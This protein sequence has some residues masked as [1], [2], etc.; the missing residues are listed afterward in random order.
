MTIPNLIQNNYERKTISQ[1]RETQSILS[2]AMRMAEEEYGDVEG[3]DLEPYSTEESILKVADKLRYF[4]KIAIDCGTYDPENK[5]LPTNDYH[6]RSGDPTNGNHSTTRYI[7]KF[8]LLNGSLIEVRTGGENKRVLTFW[9]DTNGKKLPNQYGTDYFVFAYSENSLRP[10]GAPDSDAP[11][12]QQCKNKISSGVGCAY[13]VLNNNNM[14]Y[15]R[16][17]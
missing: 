4:L 5:C 16:N 13:Y 11:Y 12:E 3:W 14:N 1:L 6:Y 15:L 2:Q 8:V 17:K 9:I 10:L 7:W